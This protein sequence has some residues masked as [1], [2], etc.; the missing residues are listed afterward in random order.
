MGNGEIAKNAFK[1]YLSCRHADLSANNMA[2]VASYSISWS[3][4]RNFGLKSNHTITPML[5]VFF[6]PLATDRVRLAADLLSD[7]SLSH[8]AFELSLLLIAT[9]KNLH[10]PR[11]SL[12]NYLSLCCDSPVDDGTF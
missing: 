5:P 2:R 3:R 10:K 6:I 9:I 11:T 1:L 7:Y 4:R 8:A 12:V